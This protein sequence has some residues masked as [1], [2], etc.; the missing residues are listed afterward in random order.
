MFGKHVLIKLIE[1]QL[2]SMKL[3]KKRGKRV[4]RVDL[5]KDEEKNYFCKIRKIKQ[6]KKLEIII[7]KI[8][9][10]QWD[11]QDFYFLLDSELSAVIS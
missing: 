1:E 6:V 7:R 8:C 4:G 9:K 11:H 5:K 10:K 3:Y 2:R